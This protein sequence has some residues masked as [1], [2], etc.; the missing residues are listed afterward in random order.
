MAKRIP[1]ADINKEVVDHA[2]RLAANAKDSKHIRD[3]I[4]GKQH[5]LQLR[6]RGRSVSWFVRAK[7]RSQKIGSAIPDPANPEYLSLQVARQR[8]GE[9]FFGMAPNLKQ[10]LSW[11]SGVL[12]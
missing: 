11:A 5:Y 1:R 2:L 4:D 3:F 9:V 8:A 12:G 10:Q 6:Q 7:G